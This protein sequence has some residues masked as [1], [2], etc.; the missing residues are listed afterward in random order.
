MNR[1]HRLA[2][3]LLAVAVAFTRPAPAAEN[4]GEAVL[5]TAEG[6]VE[7]SRTGTTGWTPAAV[8][9][10]LRVG[11]RVRT[12]ERSRATIRLANLTVLRVNEL[13]TMRIQAP[14][15]GKTAALDVDS[16]STYFFSREKPS[17]VEFRTPLTSGAIRGTEFHL[18]VAA[19]GLT[20]VALIDG[21]I[22]LQNQFGQLALNSG[23]EGVIEPGQPPRK[24]AM[25]A[26]VN[27]IQ[28]CLY[29]PGVLDVD[30]LEW[31]GAPPAD[32][33]DS[34]AAW[35]AGD[36]LAA[37]AKCDF[38]RAAVSDA[39]KIYRAALLLAVGQVDQA[40]LQLKGLA[41]NS[42]LAVALRRLVAVVKGEQV[43]HDYQPV[44]ATEWLAESYH[45]QSH[46][47]LE[48]A[49]DDAAAAATMSPNFSFAWV[50]IA[51]L[52]FGFG[53]VPPALRALERATALAPRNAQAVALKGFLLA[54]QN[55]IGAAQAQFELAIQM[56]GALGN[57]WLGRGLTRIKQGKSAEGL[58][59]LQVAA[60][61]E[62]T[63]AVLRS[64][65]G[66]AFSNGGD[67]KHAAKELAL[68]Q[69]LDPGDPTA[70]L[71]SALLAQQGNQVNDAVRDL[72]KSKALNENRGVYR[73]KLLL[74]Q[75]RAVRSA[76]LAAIY[77]DAGMTDWSVREATRAVGSDYANFSAHQFLANSYDALRDP[78]QINLRYETP[79]FSELLL[80]NLLAP[81]GAG[82]LSA[83]VSQQEYSKLFERD[84]LG[85]SSSTD[86]RSTGEW[87]QRASQ[88]GTFGNFSYALDL[89]YR[90]ERGT[91]LNN[92]L[93]QTTWTVTAKEQITPTDTLFLQVLGYDTETG[94]VAQY[95]NNYGTVAGTPAPGLGF[96][97]AERQTPNV[98]AG[99]HHEWTPGAHTLFLGGHLD[100]TLTF[101]DP[102]AQIFFQR[103]AAN[104]VSAFTTQPFQIG[105][106]REFDAWSGELQHIQQ[107]ANHTLV[108]GGRYQHGTVK[109]TNEVD[110]AGNVPP[111]I[112]SQQLK[113]SLERDTLYAYDH[114]HVW[115]PLTLI[116]GVT[117]DRVVYPQ[118][119]DTSPV[120]AGQRDRDQV[121]PKAGFIWNTCSNAFLRGAYT[122]SLGGVFYDQSVRLEPVQIAGFNQAFRSLIPES[123]VGLVPG[124]RFETFSLG[125]DQSF[126]THTYF[127][128][129][130]E[131]LNSIGDRV[132]GTTANVGFLPI[133]RAAG[134]AG[135]RLDFRERSVLV[136]LNQLVERD[137]SF[138]ARYRVS[139]A[140]L[141][142]IFPDIAVANASGANQHVNAL[143]H[144]VTL[145]AGY[146]HPC[147]FFAQTDAVWTRQSNLGYG[148][149][150]PGDDFWQ[151]NVWA[152]YRFLH[153][154]AEV[155]VGVLNLMDRDYSLNPLNLHAEQ[156]RARTFAA[157]FRFYF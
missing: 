5:L 122:R 152:G 49:L 35:R 106:K 139:D 127:S 91:R 42:P 104:V 137:F 117:Y 26:A 121:S 51:E 146:T 17:E 93:Q 23:E 46:G 4:S 124:T 151:F 144:Q 20:R 120:S 140:K 103:Q 34:L 113:G 10:P 102:A 47:D 56:D 53:K 73:S 109:V 37:V 89:E 136:T 11:D 129:E 71:Y 128:I 3:L 12:G 133:P 1:I 52:Q 125:F 45:S 28:W 83:Y 13:T 94:D 55:H 39:E 98:F 90:G 92:D 31:N 131:W 50:R 77:R 58:R 123:V 119:L 80:A 116:G 33:A 16:G 85:V 115:E 43:S 118:N 143:M 44:T 79:W 18:L 9:Q 111:L 86:Y 30:E 148:T 7:L 27:I 76:N 69:K 135:Q 100:D 81:V 14:A 132:V 29:Y 57:A 87:L 138:G 97:F 101:T 8:N 61:L 95:Y 153:R 72:E 147:G 114:W 156:P 54:A 66:K 99:W 15:P 112:S 155:R 62:P 21:L 63:R 88:Y 145:F 157:S 149:P 78:R 150:L 19:N 84:R 25:L 154:A 134:S 6:K 96:R 48:R 75:D 142:A 82:N 108:L 24:T 74:D 126:P 32:L 65:L 64:Y 22:D 67:P 68:A 2:F 36:L 41:G 59:D 107:F 141:D 70:W 60:T 130:G 40:D 105:Y 38:T 110:R